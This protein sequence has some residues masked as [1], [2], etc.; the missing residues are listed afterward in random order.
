VKPGREKTPDFRYYGDDD[1][2]AEFEA[3]RKTL[4]R[5]IKDE[6]R[7]ELTNDQYHTL[8]YRLT[9]S[10]GALYTPDKHHLH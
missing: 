7:S 5:K 10:F 9:L 1:C 4:V 8:M 6:T 2:A 3:M